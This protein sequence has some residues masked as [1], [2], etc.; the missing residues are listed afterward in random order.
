VCAH[1]RTRT[2]MRG[3]TMVSLST[4]PRAFHAS[5]Y[6]LAWGAALI[7]YF[8]EYVVRSAPAV[9]I[10]EL[11]TAFSVDAVGVSAII[12][13]YYYTYSV[14]SLAAGAALDRFGAKAPV[15]LGAVL[16]GIGCLLFVVSVPFVGYLGRL[17]QGAG[18]AFAFTGAVFLATHGFS[19]SVLATAI[20]FTQCFGMLG[21]SAGQ[22]AVGPLIHG[23]LGWKGFWVA[24]AIACLAVGAALFLITPAEGRDDNAPARE[25]LIAPFKTVFSNPQSYLCGIIAGLLFAPTTI[26]DMIWGVAFFQQDRGVEYARAVSI[27][28]MVPLGW[29]VGCPLLGWL[30]DYIGLRKPTLILGAA[31]MLMSVIA[32]AYTNDTTFNYISMFV[33]GVGS[34]AAMIPYTIIKEVNPD[35]AK[36]SAVGVINFI[37]F[38]VTAAVAP[39]FAREHGRS[40]ASSSDHLAHF[41]GAAGFWVVAIVIAIGLALFLRETG[42]K[43]SEEKSR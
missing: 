15:A 1:E 38:G 24:T 14:T 31:I 43:A 27:A 26:G 25:G 5:A 41:K 13:A 17:L 33:L 28:S 2:H 7:F 19:G 40:L 16:L 34:G 18:S 30:A 37:T 8:L 29:V 12:G 6:K 39:I 20:G 23:T 3:T 4:E 10:P 11:T 42:A 9:M 36:G 21:G 32:T 22:F 35:K